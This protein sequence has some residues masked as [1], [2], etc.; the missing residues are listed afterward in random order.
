MD[1][2]KYQNTVQYEIPK[3]VHSGSEK[4]VCTIACHLL[5][6]MAKRFKLNDLWKIYY[7]EHKQTW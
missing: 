2:L 5:G 7:T 3:T 1:L 4:R 6:T